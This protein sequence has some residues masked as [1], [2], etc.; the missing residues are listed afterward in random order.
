[1][2]YLDACLLIYL[3]ESHPLLGAPVRAALAAHPDT[4]FAISALTR[5]ECLLQPMRS[6]N[7]ALQRYNE[8]SFDSFAWLP[9]DDAVFD[10]ATQLRARHRLKTPD[11]LHLACAQQHGCEA[12]WTNDDRLAAA[13]H[14]L[15]VNLLRTSQP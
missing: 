6:G 2:V 13:G 11:A 12:L 15:A 4:R 9:I 5:M 8:A 10:L 14:G 1:M 7:L 3:V